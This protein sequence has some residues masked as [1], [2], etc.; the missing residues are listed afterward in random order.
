MRLIHTADIHLESRMSSKFDKETAKE[1]RAEVLSTFLRLIDYAVEQEVSGI[2]IAGD[3]FDVSKVSAGTLKSIRTAIE[4][5]PDITFYYLRGNHD[6]DSFLLAEETLPENLKLFDDTWTSYPVDPEGRVVI[7]GTEA[8]GEIMRYEEL[9]LPE[10]AINIVTL[11]GQECE[12]MQQG[13][14]DCIPLSMLRDR[15]IDYLALGHIHSY[16]LAP[17]DARGVYCYSGCLEGRGFDECGEK[18]F[19]LLEIDPEEGKVNPVFIPFAKRKLYEIPVDISHVEDSVAACERIAECLKN[20]KVSSQAM[21]K[22]VLNG[23]ISVDAEISTELVAER[24]SEDYYYVKV[25]DETSPHVSY[26]DYRLESSL[27]GEFVRKVYAS[28]DL[29]DDMKAKVIRCGIKALAGEEFLS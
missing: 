14:E 22:I 7:T 3:L 8:A 21:L 19:V 12:Y 18:G 10:K 2:I 24:L 26:E 6:A 13:V 15:G 16:K 28:A 9:E 5:N 29:S 20:D 4:A 27:K 11:H 25:K 23:E 1:R 17:L